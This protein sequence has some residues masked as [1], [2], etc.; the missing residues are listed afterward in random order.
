MS[1]VVLLIGF[2]RPDFVR[3]RLSEIVSSSVKPSKLVVSIDGP[4]NAS[5]FQNSDEI[6]LILE[7]F[8]VPFQV[9]LK[10]RNSNLG[11]TNHVITAVTEILKDHHEVIVIE[12]DVSVGTVFL[13]SMTKGLE[14]IRNSSDFGIVGA[15]SPFYQ[16]PLL[17]YS[18][19]SNYWRETT[20]FSAWGWATNRSFWRD[21][22]TVAE[23][24]NVSE[25]LSDS[26]LWK[27]FSERKKRIWVD[28]FEREIWD[29]NVQMTLFKYSKRCF[30]PSFRIIDNE[31]FGDSRS[32]H[33]KHMRPRNLFGV[34]LSERAPKFR[35][36]DLGN[37]IISGFWSFIDSNLWAADG[38][39]NARAR[40]AGLR[41]YAKKILRF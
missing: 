2:N 29:F 9:E 36:F 30:L 10:R 31:G 3:R 15:F 4:R 13:E 21:F 28:R 20:Y 25:Y 35:K 33:T 1:P 14:Y 41:T 11:C 37:S 38:H 12:D 22:Q 19:K 7:S 26:I 5:D 8:K 24:E 40:K 18:P 27:S 23:I 34:G 39:F 17:N 6:C 16:V 32:T